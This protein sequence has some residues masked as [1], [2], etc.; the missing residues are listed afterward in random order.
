[1]EET[2][3]RRFRLSGVLLERLQLPIVV[4]VLIAGFV[5]LGIQQNQAYLQL[6]RQQR[7]TAMQ[8]A[9]EQQQDAILQDYTDAVTNMLVNDKLLTSTT[10][11][12]VRSVAQ[13]RTTETL[14]RLDGDHK[15]VLLHF[16]YD[17][18]LINNDHRVVSMID[19]DLRGAH[20]RNLDLRDTALLGI[21]FAGADLRGANLSYAEL[22]HANLT[23]ANLAGADLH[24][25]DMHDVV[26][27]GANL[28]GA[29]L[30][31]VEGL[32]D[33]LLA[34]VKTLAGATMPDGT[35]HP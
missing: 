7:D 19:A 25:S 14:A 3:K 23:G 12:V 2:R 34:K 28:A 17:T 1:M 10:T 20:A 30:K 33:A 32:N 21:N 4:V 18:K 11:D 16:L 15:V 31:D 35:V 22:I 8:V 9:R 5:W 24:A 26:L 13:A 27:T 29:N 6:G